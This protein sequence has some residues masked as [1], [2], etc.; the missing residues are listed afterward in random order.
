MYHILLHSVESVGGVEVLK[1]ESEK[2]ISCSLKV[3][4]SSNNNVSVTIDFNVLSPTGTKHTHE[5]H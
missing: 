4:F 5:N 3:F 1:V 2:L